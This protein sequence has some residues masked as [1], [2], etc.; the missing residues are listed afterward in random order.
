MG[1][2]MAVFTEC[3]Y[4]RDV[5]AYLCTYCHKKPRPGDL[6]RTRGAAEGNRLLRKF[7]EG[8]DRSYYDWGD[9]PSFFAAQ[10]LLGD[11]QKASWGVCRPD[12]RSVVGTGDVVVLFCARQEEERVWRYYFVGFGVVRETVAPRA[13]LWTCPTYAKYRDF[14]NVLVGA[15]GGHLE[16]IHPYHDDWQPRADAPYVIFDGPLSSFNLSSP[17]CVATWD[18]RSIPEKW[19]SD[20]DPSSK[21][22]ERTLFDGIKRRLWT[23]KSGFCHAK[24]NLVRARRTTRPGRSLSELTRAL[25]QLVEIAVLSHPMSNSC[26]STAKKPN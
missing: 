18:G 1:L 22:I 19:N 15:H 13:C 25:R 9:A 2:V 24:L 16:M 11:V 17:H 10:H 7:L 12:V 14:Y 20:S 5:N 4:H 23:A 6:R 3:A 8:Y 21:E 26:L